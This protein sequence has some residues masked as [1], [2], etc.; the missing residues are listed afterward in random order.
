MVSMIVK[1]LLK[2]RLYILELSF[3]YINPLVTGIP[4]PFFKMCVLM[5]L[6][7]PS[8]TPIATLKT[9]LFICIITQII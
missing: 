4:I 6:T 1:R 3:R 9:E 7:T 2:N 8:T 5:A